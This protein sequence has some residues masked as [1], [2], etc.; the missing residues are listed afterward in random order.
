[1]R[2]NELLTG[3][4]EPL[5]ENESHAMLGTNPRAW[6]TL[7]VQT[8]D[9]TPSDINLFSKVAVMKQ[10]RRFGLSGEQKL[11]VWRRWKEGQTL[12][13]N[14]ASCLILT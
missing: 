12:H 3:C 14:S 13:D 8:V 10:G 1:V 11:E 4:S 2:T 7:P 5:L 9:A 6:L